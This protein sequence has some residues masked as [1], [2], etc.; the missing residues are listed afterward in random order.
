MKRAAQLRRRD[1]R[2]QARRERLD[3][4]AELDEVASLT[5]P[6]RLTAGRRAP[7]ALLVLVKNAATAKRCA[8]GR[9]P[10][11]TRASDSARSDS[12]SIT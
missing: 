2:A 10:S 7:D 12:S 1:A 5:A 8:S 3:A 4:R 9:Q 6:E 11:R